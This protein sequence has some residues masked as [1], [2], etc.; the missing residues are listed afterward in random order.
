LYQGKLDKAKKALANAKLSAGQRWDASKQ[1]Q[2]AA[3][4]VHAAEN[5]VRDAQ[6]AL[7]KAG[8]GLD[9]DTK[10]TLDHAQDEAEKNPPAK[11]G[12]EKVEEP[13]K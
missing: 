7:D 10:S 2:A 4:D 8:A 3:K 13:K 11:E 5:G 12:Q 1:G 6:S 9:K